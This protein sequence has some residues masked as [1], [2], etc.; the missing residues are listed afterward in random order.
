MKGVECRHFVKL[1]LKGQRQG[2]EMKLIPIN[3]QVDL[4]RKTDDPN[5]NVEISADEVILP[6]VDQEHKVDGK[7]VDLGHGKEKKKE[8]LGKGINVN[9]ETGNE[10]LGICK[11]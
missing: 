2:N 3:L 7:N 9:V 5:M 1:V 11:S 6:N 8:T 10:V 4:E